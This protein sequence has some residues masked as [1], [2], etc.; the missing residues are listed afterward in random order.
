M[1]NILFGGPQEKEREKPSHIHDDLVARLK[2]DGHEVNYVVRGD[3][4]MGNLNATKDPMN[5]VEY[6]LVLYDTE[7][8]YDQAKLRKRIE[9]FKNQV[10]YWLKCAKAPIIVLADEEI[11]EEIRESVK[12]AKFK[13]INK[14]Y[15][16]DDVVKAVDSSL[17]Y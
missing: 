8:F 5:P 11:A 12:N 1:V 9:V 10:I 16:I 3:E 6:D 4:M 2:Q 14:P 17:S 15:N 7:L 13:Q